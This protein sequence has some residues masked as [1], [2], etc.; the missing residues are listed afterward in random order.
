VVQQHRRSP[1]LRRAL[2]AGNDD[3]A[4]QD[5]S[6]SASPPTDPNDFKAWSI[7]EIETIQFDSIVLSQDME[8]PSNRA[9]HAAAILF[10]LLPSSG[11]T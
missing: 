11:A 2:A 6:R 1:C 4:R 8:L 5:R 10:F 3:A 7:T 9:Y